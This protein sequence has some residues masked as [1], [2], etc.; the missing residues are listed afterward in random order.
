[1]ILV[2]LCTCRV[3]GGI[4]SNRPLCQ[5]QDARTFN[6]SE[7]RDMKTLHSKLTNSSLDSSRNSKYYELNSD[8]EETKSSRKSTSIERAGVKTSNDRSYINFESSDLLND[9]TSTLKID[10][11][12]V[13]YD[14]DSSVT[15]VMIIGG[16]P[17]D[18][19]YSIICQPESYINMS[20]HIICVSFKEESTVTTVGDEYATEVKKI[21]IKMD[22]TV[23]K[24]R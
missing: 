12:H 18:M 8:I 3:V 16:A 17:L 20:P 10:T 15:L 13:F 1:M 22:L 6:T 19:V 2:V 11:P 21:K 14:S 9:V 4:L 7:R 24:K 23:S 5:S